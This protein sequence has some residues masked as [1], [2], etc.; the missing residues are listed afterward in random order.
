MDCASQVCEV[1]TYIFS[2]SLEWV[3]I[4][5]KT[6]CV[7]PVPKTVHPKELNHFRP[8]TL[9]SHRIPRLLV[10]RDLVSRIRQGWT[11]RLSSRINRLYFTMFFRQRGIQAIQVRQ[12]REMVQAI[13]G[14]TEEQGEVGD[15]G[16]ENKQVSMLGQTDKGTDK[17]GLCALPKLATQ[18]YDTV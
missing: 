7:V 12:A 16:R 13:R 5:W 4:L 1:I 17:T 6:S 9:P 2:L 15:C 14:A 10:I 8:V 18:H 3:P 11:L